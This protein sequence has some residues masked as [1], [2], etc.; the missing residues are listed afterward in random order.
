MLPPLEFNHHFLVL[1]IHLHWLESF[2]CVKSRFSSKTLTEKIETVTSHT[3]WSHTVSIM[4]SL[5][6]SNVIHLPIGYLSDN[7]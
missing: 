1:K 4:F 5:Q 3:F 7:T 6:Q 2:L